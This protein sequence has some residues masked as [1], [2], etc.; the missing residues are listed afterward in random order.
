[1]RRNTNATGTWLVI[2]PS[3]E[4]M[5]DDYA[6]DPQFCLLPVD[7]LL[8]LP[9][10]AASRV[11]RALTSRTR[12]TEE[13]TVLFRSDLLEATP[14]AEQAELGDQWD[15]LWR[16]VAE[17]RT[18]VWV[19]ADHWSESAVINGGPEP[20]NQVEAWDGDRETLRAHCADRLRRL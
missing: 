16:S 8:D 18:S 5:P 2:G 14:A 10:P 12:T 4:D 15:A 1:M 20:G 9:D 6:S 17:P 19:K 11:H 13:L 3:F 7:S